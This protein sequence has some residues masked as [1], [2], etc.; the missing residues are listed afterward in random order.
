MEVVIWLCMLIFAILIEIATMGLTTIWFAGGALF[1]V[2][3]AALGAHIAIQIGLFLV[4]SLGLLFFTRPIAVKYFNKDRVAT[5]V[6]GI[7]GKQAVV[8]EE[9]DNLKATGLVT[10]DGQEWTARASEDGNVIP[11]GAV[12]T[13]V[14]VSGVKVI[15]EEKVE[16]EDK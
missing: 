5:N 12:V 4:V 9:I 16:V 7:I 8:V 6:E 13:V 14:K 15:V 1:A 11:K 10:V 2:I 3:A